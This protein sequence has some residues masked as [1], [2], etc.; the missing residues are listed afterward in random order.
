MSL[1]PMEYAF[2]SSQSCGVNVSFY[3]SVWSVAQVICINDLV[4]G[5]YICLCMRLTY[6]IYL[7]IEVETKWQHNFKQHLQMFLFF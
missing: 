5:I 4:N 3:I 7:H 1:P 6:M 2:L